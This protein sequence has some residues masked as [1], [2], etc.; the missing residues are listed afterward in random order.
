MSSESV[1]LAGHDRRSRHPRRATP[2]PARVRRQG[3]NVRVAAGV[4]SRIGTTPSRGSMTS[5]ARTLEPPP[6]VRLRSRSL[7]PGSAP[8]TV[9]LATVQWAFCSEGLA[10]VSGS[11]RAVFSGPPRAARG[12]E[13]G[14]S[15][16]W[17]STRRSG[18][19]RSRATSASARSSSTTPRCATAS[20]PP[21]SSSP[22]PR[23]SRSRKYLD[24]IGV[25]P[26]RGR[27][28]GHGRRRA[29]GHRGDRA[30]GPQGLGSGL[31][32]RE[33]RR[34]QDLDRLRRRRGRHLA[35]DERHPH[36][37]QA[38]EGPQVGPRLDPRGGRVR[39]EPRACTSRST[40]RTRAAPSSASCSSTP[41]PPRPR[42][43]TA[44]ASATR[45]ASWS[46]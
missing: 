32:P 36:R 29:R 45:S 17:R 19:C 1:A 24:E 34:H 18:S 38:H 15:R 31:E 13:R 7:V 23:R 21:A 27:H 33:R 14:G 22:T 9:R 12:S 42:A 3:R 25:A 10:Q 16:T 35:R 5:S 28:P 43:P 40:P 26:D 11:S 30:P 6:V 41:R 2:S 37:D 4:P 46:R 44:C 8:D 20:R 39:Q